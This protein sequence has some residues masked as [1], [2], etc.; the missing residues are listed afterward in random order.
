MNSTN[1]DYVAKLLLDCF[2]A[3]R[4]KMDENRSWSE[5]MHANNE[6]ISFVKETMELLDLLQVKESISDNQVNLAT[7]KLMQRIDFIQ[8]HDSLCADIA[9][10]AR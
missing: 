9:E 7:N 4:G 8:K 1:D 2:L 5:W 3:C 6:N 10:G